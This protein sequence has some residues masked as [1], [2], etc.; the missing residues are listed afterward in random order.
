MPAGFAFVE[1][2]FYLS[3]LKPSVEAK[4]FKLGRIYI[5]Q[6][7]CFYKKQINYIAS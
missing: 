1:F 7:F 5:S 3:S 4:M 6:F 2:S